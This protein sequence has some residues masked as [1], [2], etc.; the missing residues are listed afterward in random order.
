MSVMRAVSGRPPPLSNA[1]DAL[2]PHLTEKGYELAG[3]A[4]ESYLEGQDVPQPR[5]RVYQP[6]QS[7]DHRRMSGGTA[8]STGDI[9]V[10]CAVV[11]GWNLSARG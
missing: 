8:P 1:Y 7:A 6:V 5:A 11:I 4:W 3:A 2:M 10:R 9:E